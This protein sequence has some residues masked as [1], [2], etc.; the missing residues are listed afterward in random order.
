MPD[1]LQY[2][3]ISVTVADELPGDSYTGSKPPINDQSFIWPYWTIRI[4]AIKL[5]QAD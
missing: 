2:I 1:F 4:I 5:H 3:Y